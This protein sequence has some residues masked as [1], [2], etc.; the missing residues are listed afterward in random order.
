MPPVKITLPA[1]HAAGLTQSL[2][3]AGAFSVSELGPGQL[4][5]EPAEGAGAVRPYFSARKVA[6]PD[7]DLS[8]DAVWAFLG[9]SAPISPKP[10]MNLPADIDSQ[11]AALVQSDQLSA[12]AQRLGTQVA[13][14]EVEAL[15]DLWRAELPALFARYPQGSL[16]YVSVDPALISRLTFMRISLQLTLAPDA[17]TGHGRNGISYF[18]AHQLTGGLS[19]YELMQLPLLA[20]SPAAAGLAFNALPHAFVFL[21]GEL[22]DLRT[23]APGP[24][25]RSFFPPVSSHP[26]VPG[27]KVPTQNL[28]TAHLEALM[29]WWTTRLNILYSHAA[30]PTRFVTASG[31]HDA[32]GQAAWFFTFERMLADYIALAAS[33]DSPGL[34]RVQA[35]F[36]ALDKAA[37]LLAGAGGKDTPQFRRLL[38]RGE[39][40]PRIHAALASLPLQLQARFRAWTEQAYDQL[41]AD[42]TAQ[43]M[44]S[45]VT[46]QG[47]LVGRS[48]PTDLQEEA[49]DEYV[50]DLLREARNSSHGLLS[51]LTEPSKPNRRPRRL[52]L[53][54]NQ[55]EVPASLFEVTR[56]AVFGLLADATALT[57]RSW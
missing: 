15:P 25:A 12:L 13:L 43:C 44:P 28:A 16:W 37:S 6:R 53:A 5:V 7:T 26:Y 55:G 27:I 30:D 34:L 32:P 51:M 31:E 20:F 3:S 40:V 11:L 4:E 21:F 8:D 52:L 47:I 57:A 38:K 19:F 9:V 23:H 18:G 56:A 1:Q 49:F 42:I 24:L 45:R 54:T 10:Q 36:D 46:Q 14:T 48:S 50:A 22:E 39:A 33:V 29:G 17:A 2:K 41:Y 35:A